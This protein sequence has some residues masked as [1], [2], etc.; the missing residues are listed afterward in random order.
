[1]NNLIVITTTYN[2]PKRIEMIGHLKSILDKRSDIT[3]IVVEDSDK[4]NTDLIEF[5]PKYAIYLNTGP[6]KDKGHQQRNLALEYIYDQS[7]SGIIYNADDDNKYDSRLFDE[8][9]KTK[10]FSIFPVGN[11]GP[12]CIEKPVVSDGK[13][14]DWDANWKTRKYP[15]D[16]AGF[17]FHSNNLNKLVKPFWK[18][19][20]LGGETE[21][22]EKCISS[23]DDLEILCNN[24]TE[25]Y[26]WHNG[27]VA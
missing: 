20:G 23:K 16:M 22:I 2:R 8:I 26:V 24:C 17:A 1:M 12:N 6:S 7:M 13:I 27:L 14:I 11:L 4:K 5:L 9:K 3:W 10:N 19:K 18:F 25:T 21:F 15:V